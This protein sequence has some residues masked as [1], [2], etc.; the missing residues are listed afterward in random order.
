MNDFVITAGATAALLVLAGYHAMAPR[1]QVYGRTFVG[2]RDGNQSSKREIALTF[3]DGPNDP[4]TFRLL[5][6]LAERGI[7]ATFFMIG[8]YVDRRPDIARAVADAGHAV[9][10]HTYTHP[11]LIFQSQ[12]QLRDEIS[13]CDRALRDAIGE[14]RTKLFRP[15]F[16]GRR[17]ATLRTVRAMGFT[18]V[19]W[20]VTGFDWNA[21]SRDEIERHVTKEVRGGDVV[22]LHDGGHLRFGTDRSFTVQATERLIGRYLAEGYRFVTIPEMMGEPVNG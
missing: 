12:S 9:G 16:G 5:E 19:M 13:R 20:N 10:N 7:R 2:N 15:P 3:D 4:Y 6:L 14:R 11:N 1:S 17:P 18:P 21:K 22:L 8:S